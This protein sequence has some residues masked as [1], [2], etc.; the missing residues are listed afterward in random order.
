MPNTEADIKTPLKETSL[1]SPVT[2]F[3]LWRRGRTRLRFYYQFLFPEILRGERYKLIPGGIKR[4][5]QL[6]NIFFCMLNLL[7]KKDFVPPARQST[8]G[9]KP[10]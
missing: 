3:A 8:R 4:L 5:H 2:F 10:S 6:F 7:N 1:I 9:T